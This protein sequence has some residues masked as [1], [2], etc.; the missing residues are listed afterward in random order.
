MKY[1]YE[2]AITVLAKGSIDGAGAFLKA[3]C[4]P[5]ADEFGLLV[6]DRVIYWRAQNA[7]KIAMKAKRLLKDIDISN[8]SAPPR[9]VME[10]IEKGSW[11]SE[12]YIQNCW[13]GLSIFCVG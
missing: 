6:K 12:D 2:E 1:P 8:Q 3:I 9:I 4:L 11:N 10:I 5:A 7:I 13:A